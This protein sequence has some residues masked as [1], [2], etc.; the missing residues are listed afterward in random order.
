MTASSESSPAFPEELFGER[1]RKDLRQLLALLQLMES[2]HLGHSETFR[3]RPIRHVTCSPLPANFLN[4]TG[5]ANG[6][7][8]KA[9]ALVSGWSSEASL[10]LSTLASVYQSGE[11]SPRAVLETVLKRIAAYRDRSVW[12]HRLSSEAVLVRADDVAQRRAAG[13]KLPLFGI[14]FAIKDAIDVAGYPTTAGCP[15]Y[16]HTAERTAPAVQNLLDAGAILVGKTNLDQFGTGLAGDRSPYGICHNVFNPSYISGGSSSGSAVAMAAGLVSFAL[17]TDTAGSGRVPAGCNNIVGFKPTPGTIS[18]EGVVPSCKS[19]D[20]VSIFALTAD[21]ARSVFSVAI[22][23]NLPRRGEAPDAC[24]LPPSFAVPRDEDLEFFGDKGFETSFHQAIGRMEQLGWQR[25]TFDFQP[26]R[27]VTS[28]LYEGPWLA[29]RLAGLSD[30]MRDHAAGMHPVTRTVIQGGARYSAADY[31]R[32]SYRLKELREICLKVFDQADMLVL[33]TMPTCPTLADVQSDSVAWSRRLGHYTNFVNLLG[34]A[35]IAVPAAFT[36]RGLPFGITM[37]GPVGSDERLLEWGMTWQRH[38]NLPLG[39]TRQ[40]IPAK[41]NQPNAVATNVV[42]EGHV[43][44]AVAGAHLRGQPLH[45]ALREMGG[46]FVRVDRTA[47]Q[48]RFLAFTDLDP[49]RPGLLRDPE[50]AGSIQIELYDLPMAGFGALVDSVASP[51]SIGT[52]ELQDGTL[53]KGFLCESW[54]ARKA[55]DITDFGNWAAF[56]SRKDNSL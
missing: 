4:A 7:E 29:E 38:V 15:A 2:C 24:P 19:L 36:E 33:P 47:A 23:E 18:T 42:T 5:L 50:R 27:E 20:C 1:N 35:A 26:F 45:G 3:Q 39:A 25:M 14:P 48:Y 43:Q 34:L 51:L 13:E 53:V 16:C 12:I 9:R 30:F 11:V 21:D 6:S 17:G 28:L 55:Q 10:D 32:S 44:L 46:R 56:L 37:I 8:L 49:P 52:I 41:N 31:F 40:A 54:A 22:G